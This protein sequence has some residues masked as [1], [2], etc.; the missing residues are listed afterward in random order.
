MNYQLW[1]SASHRSGL[2]VAEDDESQPKAAD[3]QLLF[4]V[5]ANTLD[6]ARQ[7]RDELLERAGVSFAPYDDPE[8]VQELQELLRRGA[9]QPGRHRAERAAA[10]EPTTR[11]TTVVFYDGHGNERSFE[12]PGWIG[13]T[14]RLADHAGEIAAHLSQAEEKTGGLDTTLEQV[15]VERPYRDLSTAPKELTVV[16]LRKAD[17]SGMRMLQEFAGRIEDPALLAALV[18]RRLGA[19]GVDWR[20]DEVMAFKRGG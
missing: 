11:V 15:Y 12:V 14:T 20:F 16:V 17:K 3:A 7:K 18:G 9:E 5:E 2:L 6:E 19:N 1:Y 8:A 4:V 10:D 13:I